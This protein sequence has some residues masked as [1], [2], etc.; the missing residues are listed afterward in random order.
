MN[1]EREY[2]RCEYYFLLRLGIDKILSQYTCILKVR[3][4]HV[5]VMRRSPN[6]CK[7]KMQLIQCGTVQKFS[8]TD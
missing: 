5:I 8:T 6:R 4:T 2:R 7:Q 1:K 3:D